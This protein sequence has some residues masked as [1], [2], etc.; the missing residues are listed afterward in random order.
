MSISN[1]SKN[2]INNL[3]LPIIEIDNKNHAIMEKV[4]K[5][6]AVYSQLKLILQQANML[7]QQANMIINEALVNE[8]LHNISCKFKKIS[9]KTYHLYQK[10]DGDKYFSMIS[11]TEWTSKDL[12]L[13][14]Y[15]YDY[16]KTFV[17]V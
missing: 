15:F 10:E 2:D 4:K 8:D 3:L 14:S 13:N 17:L 9:G 6:A 16:D 5:N 11:P 7:K 1:L 12:F